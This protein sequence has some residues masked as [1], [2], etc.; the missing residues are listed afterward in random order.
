MPGTGPLTGLEAPDFELRDQH[1]RPTRLSSFRGS[2]AVVVMF[3]PYAFSRV[4][5]G[6]LS[7]VRDHPAFAHA[8]VQLLAVSCD[9]MFA[10]RAL[11]ERDALSFPLLSDFWPHG[12]VARAYGV[13]DEERGCAERSTFIVDRSGW[14]RWVVHNPMPE[15]RDLE[16]QV[17]VLGEV[18]G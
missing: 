7:A 11:A 17:R 18:A 15:A 13:F 3:Y 14:V 8:G 12:E 10:L 5:T 2:Q 1:G 16:E 6:E 4:C 9:P